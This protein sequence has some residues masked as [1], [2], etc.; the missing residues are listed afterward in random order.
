LTYFRGALYESALPTTLD[1]GGCNEVL[2]DG[3]KMYSTIIG[4]SNF[5]PLGGS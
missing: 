5:K 4:D 1:G 2:K 3:Q